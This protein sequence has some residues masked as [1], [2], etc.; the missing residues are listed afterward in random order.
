MDCWSV[1]IKRLN[2]NILWEEVSPDNSKRR[3]G[4][5]SHVISRIDRIARTGY[6]RR[7]R[8]AAGGSRSCRQRKSPGSM[9]RILL[10]TRCASWRQTCCRY[11][12]WWDRP[13]SWRVKRK[14]EDD[15]KSKVLFNICSLLPVQQPLARL[16]SSWHFLSLDDAHDVQDAEDKIR[17]GGR[18]CSVSKFSTARVSDL[19]NTAWKM[20]T[21]CQPDS[22][23]KKDWPK[24]TE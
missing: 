11:Q 12:T 3:I 8:A 5:G 16:W 24:N 22:G 6:T 9:W 19:E 17:E 7:G 18:E 1:R 10:T 4:D 14:P 15:M 2:S 23:E 20:V 13:R 21:P